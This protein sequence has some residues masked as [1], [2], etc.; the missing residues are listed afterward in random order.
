MLGLGRN[1]VRGWPGPDHWALWASV[2]GSG[3]IANVHVGI[4]SL[5]PSTLPLLGKYLLKVGGHTTNPALPLEFQGLRIYPG[6]PQGA[7]N[8]GLHVPS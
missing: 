4:P 7:G 5:G 2:R 6:R 1:K 3:F 8:S